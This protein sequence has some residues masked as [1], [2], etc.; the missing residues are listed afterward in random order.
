MTLAV[1]LHAPD[2]ELRDT[3]VPVNRRWKVAEVLAAAWDYAGA[4]GRRVSVD[5]YQVLADS[6]S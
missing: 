2:D 5:R 1:S 4:T 6:R 3:L